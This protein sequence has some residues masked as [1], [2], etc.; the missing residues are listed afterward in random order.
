MN[1]TRDYP[2]GSVG[3]LWVSPKRGFTQNNIID[4]GPREKDVFATSSVTS[5]LTSDHKQECIKG[6]VLAT[7]GDTGRKDYLKVDS[8]DP[9]S[10]KS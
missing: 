10:R 1:L 7:Q 8:E 6:I 4:D 2:R 3:A 5:E 9:G